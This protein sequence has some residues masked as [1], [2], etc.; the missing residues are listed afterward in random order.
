MSH[1]PLC[2]Q[3]IDINSTLIF[4]DI[5]GVILEDRSTPYFAYK[6]LKTFEE[7]FGGKVGI[8][9]EYT[10]L[11]WR[12][13]TAR[14]LTEQP[15][16]NL[17]R[18][19]D[20][21]QRVHRSARIVLSSAWRNNGTM[22][23]IRDTMFATHEFSKLIIGKTPPADGD[24]YAPEIQTGQKFGPIAKEKYGL[25]LKS[26]AE[27]IDF[28]LREHALQQVDFVI[29]DDEDDSLSHKFGDRFVHVDYLLSEQE[30]NLACKILHL[31]LFG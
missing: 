9:R 30:I 6:I 29:L 19:I 18:L 5:D 17:Y 25:S 22:Q 8:S 10:A 31:E 7:V 3:P 28:W 11:E 15:L 27:Q 26:R 14:N 16:D 13:V 2:I 12:T 23:E 4:L 21:I 20:R 1:C 24:H